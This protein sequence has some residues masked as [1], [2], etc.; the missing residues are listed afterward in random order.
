MKQQDFGLTL[1]K[2]R[3]LKA[4]FLDVRSSVVPWSELY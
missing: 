2:R 3:M 1:C 4:V